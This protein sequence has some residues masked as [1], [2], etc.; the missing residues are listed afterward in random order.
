MKKKVQVGIFGLAK[1]GS[2]SFAYLGSSAICCW[3]DNENNRINFALRYRNEILHDIT[4]PLWQELDYIILSPGVPLHFPKPHNIVKIATQF[5]IPLISDIEWLYMSHPNARYIA[6]TGTNGKST[7][8]ALIGHI[9]GESFAVGGNIGV[10][11]LSL[12]MENDGYVLELS[13]YQLDL[14]SS[15]RANIAVLL[16]IT[17][18]HIE[19]HGSMDGYIAAKKRIWQNMRNGDYLVIGIDNDITH[20]IYLELEGKVPFELVPISA[21][22]NI[23]KSKFLLGSHNRENLAAAVAVAKILGITQQEI[24][25]KVAS[26]KGLPHRM[27]YVGSNNNVAFYN[28][29]KATNSDAASKSLS[30][31]EDIY[32]LAGGLPKEGGIE[33][34]KSLF[35]RITKAYLFGAAKDEFA[36]T[37]I[38]SKVDFIICDNMSEALELAYKDAMGKKV[39]I[40]LAPACASFDQF[41]SFEH[42]GEEF[43]RLCERFITQT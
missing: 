15:F 39:N 42:R 6:I 28:D 3:D 38:K 8:T 4:D 41:E 27:Q 30:A 5:Q 40:L 31:L 7:T 20:K 10:P 36:Q 25:E 34:L 9:L 32:W 37:L 18:D 17:P 26:F 33:P 24:E 21:N 11:A 2:A 12:P 35:P 23:P 43:I 19:R 14:L 16:N 1:T 22:D 13:S 29:S